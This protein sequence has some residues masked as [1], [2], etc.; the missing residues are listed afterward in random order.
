MKLMNQLT[1]RFLKQNKKRTILTII[2][3]TISVVMMSCVG[4]GLYSGQQMYRD[5]VS[6]TEGDFHYK[7]VSNHQEVINIIKQDDEVKEYYF[8]N[9]QYPSYN[10]TTLSVKNGDNKYYDKL[11]FQKY[12]VDGRLP[13]NG[14]EIA[15]S[16][17]FIET[18]KKHIGDRIQLQYEEDN[19]QKVYI[20]VGVIDAFHERNDPSLQEYDAIGYVDFSESNVWYTL[21]VIDKEVSYQIFEHGNQLTEK[22]SS[23][24]DTDSHNFIDYHTGYLA[25]QMVF[26]QNS[27]SSFIFIYS[28][29]VILLSI[30]VVISVFIIYQAFQLSIHDRILYLG[31]LSSVGATPKQK[32]KSIYFEGL[33]LSLIAVPLGILASFIGLSIT[34]MIIN[35]YDFMKQLDLQ[36]KAG[37]S[38]LYLFC[39]IFLSIITIF[40]SLYLPARKLSRI[41]A[42]DILKKNNDLKSKKLKIGFLV[43]KLDIYKQFAV[44]NYKR[45]GKRSR[46]II[47]SLVI[48]MVSF[49]SIYSFTKYSFL[50]L[51]NNMQ[52]DV[53]LEFQ[54]NNSQL[55]QTHISQIISQLESSGLVDH[56]NYSIKT[57]DFTALLNPEYIHFDLTHTYIANVDIGENAV[58][59]Y[60]YVL[61]EKQYQKLCQQQNIPIDKQAVLF[62][63]G[64]LYYDDFEGTAELIEDPFPDVDKDM[65]ESLCFDEMNDVSLNYNLYKVDSYLDLDMMPGINLFFNIDQIQSLYPDDFSYSVDFEINSHQSNELVEYLDNTFEDAII[66]DYAQNNI[67]QNNFLFIFQILVYGFVSIMIFFTL[68]N[69]INMMSESIENRKKEFAMMLSVGMSPKGLYKVI[70]Y[71]SLIYG[72]KTLIYAMPICIFIEYIFYQQTYIE[73]YTFMISFEA[74]FICFIIIMFVMLLTFRTG[75]KALKRQNIIEALKDD[76]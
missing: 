25:T 5:Y 18:H 14:N 45:Q 32:R 62:Y 1:L 16:K 42:I 31:M 74:Y 35:Q 40:I 70:W 47:I 33:I 53:E 65:I 22:M 69:I 8:S 48:S 54:F 71:E 66:T 56:Y 61:D 4:I 64:S 60:G 41:S 20:I 75:L 58:N 50:Q 55:N 6:Q 51:E 10:Q 23:Y 24:I 46:V 34:F 68:V 67:I 27:Y 7:I 39:V 9:T 28:I 76:M 49:I 19:T 44:K 17:H 15:V 3:M 59:A 30:I 26:E 29:A 73:G 36:L 21:Y 37:I 11:N 72:I 57:I 38:P 63:C 12:I 52:P 43:K 2:C 13:E